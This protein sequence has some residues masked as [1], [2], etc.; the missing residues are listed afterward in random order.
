M[1]SAIGDILSIGFVLV[2]IF[3]SITFSIAL[4]S[5]NQRRLFGIVSAV[6][7]A[8][9]VGFMVVFIIGGIFFPEAV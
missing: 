6:L 2:L 3:L 7:V 5:E 4:I 1:L 8:I 9:A